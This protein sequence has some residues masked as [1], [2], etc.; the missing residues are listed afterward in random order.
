MQR[1]KIL[2]RSKPVR[3]KRVSPFTATESPSRT[4]SSAGRTCRILSLLPE[5]AE[6]TCGV[7]ST[8]TSSEGHR[9]Q[10]RAGTLRQGILRQNPQGP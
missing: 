8:A 6:E 5:V 10:H 7:T 1:K 3:T 4:W 9:Q 2:P